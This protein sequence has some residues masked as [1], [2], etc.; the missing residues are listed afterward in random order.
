MVWLGCVLKLVGG[1]YMLLLCCTRLLLLARGPTGVPLANWTC[2]APWVGRTPRS[3][4]PGSSP[5]SWVSRHASIGCLGRWQ[6]LRWKLASL[7]R[8]GL[9]L[10]TPLSLDYAAS[11]PLF[12]GA[13]RGFPH[14]IP[15][16]KRHLT[17]GVNRK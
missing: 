6:R 8:Q 15:N 1:H 4:R 14:R 5:T 12:P 2:A 16:M 9:D 11:K 13:L 7:A 3:A 10:G 17:S